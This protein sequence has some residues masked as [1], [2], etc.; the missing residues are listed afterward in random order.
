MDFPSGDGH[1]FHIYP[2]HAPRHAFRA[3]WK[4][5]SCEG[6][7]VEEKK[8]L[9]QFQSLTLNF[10]SQVAEKL[11]INWNEF[12]CSAIKTFKFLFSAQLFN[13]LRAGKL[14]CIASAAFD[15]FTFFS[16]IE[17]VDV[18]TSC[19]SRWNSLLFFGSYAVQ[20]HDRALLIISMSFRYAKWT[21]SKFFSSSFFFACFCGRKQSKMLLIKIRAKI[22]VFAD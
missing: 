20:L 4:M 19:C 21:T 6:E 5:K 18:I 1:D 12:R 17:H 10:I 16:L 13:H 8:S 9:N 3:A 22:F 14:L 15:W 2:V 7:R 11:N